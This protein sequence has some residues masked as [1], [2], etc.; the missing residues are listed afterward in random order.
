MAIAFN[1]RQ[2]NMKPLAYMRAMQLT[3]ILVFYFSYFQIRDPPTEI[4]GL[5]AP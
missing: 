1:I 2:G 4:S 5:R 3:Y